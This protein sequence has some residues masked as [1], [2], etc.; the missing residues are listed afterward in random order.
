MQITYDMTQLIV[1]IILSCTSLI[2]MIY[3]LIEKSDV[4]DMPLIPLFLTICIFGVLG[5]IMTLIGIE[6]LYIA[7]I[8][9]LASVGIFVLTYRGFKSII[10]KPTDP[11]DFVGQKALVEIAVAPNS[12]GRIKT[13]D[14]EHPVEFPSKANCV[15]AKNQKVMIER[16]SWGFAFVVPLPDNKT[17]RR[18]DLTQC[19]KC[20]S[21]I[22]SAND[23]C[24]H[25]GEER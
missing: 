5:A 15:I 20:R 25:C 6:L 7:V 9:T 17:I 3:L 11:R 4:V 24:P 16:F 19:T 18:S 12:T 21:L 13:L 1:F 10:T 14:V 2:A 23:Y 8:T 22:D